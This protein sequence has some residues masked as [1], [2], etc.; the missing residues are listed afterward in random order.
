MPRFLLVEE[1]MPMWRGR[2][3]IRCSYSFLTTATRPNFTSGTLVDMYR[4]SRYYRFLP[5]KLLNWIFDDFRWYA[6]SSL[7]NGRDRD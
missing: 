7:P 3:S 6:T 4:F 1:I 2:P 5:C